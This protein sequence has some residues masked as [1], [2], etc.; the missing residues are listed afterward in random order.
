M[1]DDNDK[2]EKPTADAPG[3]VVPADSARH[4][5]ASA[6]PDAGE[7]AGSRRGKSGDG[8]AGEVARGCGQRITG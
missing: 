7:A 6:I 3:V 4:A 2:P 1:A 5:A 8:R